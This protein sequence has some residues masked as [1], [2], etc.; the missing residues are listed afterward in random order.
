MGTVR[1]EHN[2]CGNGEYASRL[3]CLADFKMGQCIASFKDAAT[4]TYAHNQSLIPKLPRPV[5]RYSSVQVGCNEHVELNS[6]F[7]YL[8]H[9]CSPNVAVDTEQWCFVAYRDISAGDELTFFYPST[10]WEMAQ[11]F[12]C[13]CGSPHVRLYG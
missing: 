13:W 3:I 4:R 10:E 2:A 12:E 5:K 1:V 6:D 11:P 7:V 9:S 8:N